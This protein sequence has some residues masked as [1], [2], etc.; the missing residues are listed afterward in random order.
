[1]EDQYQ[2]IAEERNCVNQELNELF[3]EKSEKDII[4]KS[5]T[6]ENLDLNN[7]IA[8]LEQLLCVKED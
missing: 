5:L 1:M 2:R 3:A 7:K 6:S 8:A 4:I